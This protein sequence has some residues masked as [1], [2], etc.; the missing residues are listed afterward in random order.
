MGD[1][2]LGHQAL[3]TGNESITRKPG[4]AKLIFKYWDKVV[5]PADHIILL[6]N[7]AVG[8]IKHWF[9]RLAPLPGRKVLLLGNRERNRPQ[10]Y[11]RFNIERVVPFNQVLLMQSPKKYE[12]LGPVMLSHLP[13]IGAVMRPNN[14]PALTDK[15]MDIWNNTSPILN[16]HSHTQG[17]GYED[18]RTFDAGVDVIGYAPVLLEQI[19]ELHFNAKV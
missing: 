4:W 11:K 7:I 19:M 14:Y 3:L 13:V 10:W 9:E 16:I 12:H 18:H 2:H 1:L 5:S 17:L 6:G 15:F 8:S